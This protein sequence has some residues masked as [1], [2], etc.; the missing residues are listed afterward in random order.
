MAQV[1]MEA[2]QSKIYSVG[3][4]TGDPGRLVVQFQSKQ[5]QTQ[6]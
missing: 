3:H 4:Y 1:I 5:R 2:D 6:T